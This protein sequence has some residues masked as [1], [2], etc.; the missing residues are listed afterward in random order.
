MINNDIIRRLR[1]VFDY[2]NAK[3]IKIF[4]QANVEFSTDEI[5]SLLKKKR[6]KATKPVMTRLCVS[7]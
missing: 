3:M 2:S 5:I 1:F 6:K 7:S 4:A